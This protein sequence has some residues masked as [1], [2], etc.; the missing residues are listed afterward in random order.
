[1]N[2]E[3]A[4][5]KRAKELRDGIKNE[6]CCFDCRDKYAEK[7]S[8]DGI[9]TMYTS[10]CYVCQENKTVTSSSKLFGHHVFL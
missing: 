2:K 6:P 1:M 9:Y 3:S 7:P 8:Y 10:S 4:E 5:A